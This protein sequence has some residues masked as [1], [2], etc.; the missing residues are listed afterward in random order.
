M[1]DYIEEFCR[2][3][4]QKVSGKIPIKDVGRN[5]LCNIIFIITKLASSIG[6]HLALKS[7]MEIAIECLEP[8]IFNWSYAVLINLKDQL[9]RCKTG[10]HKQFGYGSI[11]V[12][13]FLEKIQLLQPQIVHLVLSSTLISS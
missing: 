10:K 1:E 2:V 4:T 13:F 8:K 5:P 12:S 3:G 6:S 7:R 11:L 9:S